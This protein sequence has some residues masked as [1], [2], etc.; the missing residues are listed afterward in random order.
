LPPIQAILPKSS[1]VAGACHLHMPYT[2]LKGSVG[3]YLLSDLQAVSPLLAV[4]TRN[5]CLCPNG[6]I[7]ALVFCHYNKG[8]C[9]KPFRVFSRSREQKTKRS[10]CCFLVCTPADM[11]TL[12]REGYLQAYIASKWAQRRFAIGTLPASVTQLSALAASAIF[13]AMRHK[14]VPT[15]APSC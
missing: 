15:A 10:M 6:G 3:C 1:F 7:L 5:G 9:R 11:G 8:S 13:A 2:F 4:K 12:R 14:T